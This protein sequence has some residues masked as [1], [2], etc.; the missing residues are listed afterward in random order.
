MNW[1]RIGDALLAV[2][3]YAFVALML[4]SWIYV[5]FTGRGSG[6]TSQEQ[7]LESSAR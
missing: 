1:D 7:Y 3:T 5:A 6:P 4:F 2:G